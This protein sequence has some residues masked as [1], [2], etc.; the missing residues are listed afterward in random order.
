MKLVHLPAKVQVLVV[1]NDQ[2]SRLAVVAPVLLRGVRG[3]KIPSLIG[4][5]TNWVTNR[6]A[7]GGRGEM[8]LSCVCLTVV[9]DELAKRIII[10]RIVSDW[11]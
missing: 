11:N 3:G 1:A 2:W 6:V 9:L 5:N 7:V 4:C 8:A 10:S